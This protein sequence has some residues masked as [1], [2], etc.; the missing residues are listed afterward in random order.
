ML[1]RN[2]AL[3]HQLA[4]VRAALY[5]GWGSPARRF[6]WELLTRAPRQPRAHA[7]VGWL[8]LDLRGA[9]GHIRPLLS[10]FP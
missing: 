1:L 5:G 6:S 7:P 4:T 2:C 10:D 9:Q 3:G 8:G